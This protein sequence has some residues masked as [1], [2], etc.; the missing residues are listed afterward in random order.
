MGATV[1]VLEAERTRPGTVVPIGELEEIPRP[2]VSV[3]GEITQLW[4]PSSPAIAQV[5]LIED[6]TGRTK[7]TAWKRSQV[8]EVREGE[9][10][11]F[12]A[13]AKNWYQGQCSVA[14]TGDSM[15]VRL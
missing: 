10:V 15:V 14:L 7:W 3:E 4:T 13:I 5:G 9:T 12:R 2:E 8:R 6:E 1:R 11:R